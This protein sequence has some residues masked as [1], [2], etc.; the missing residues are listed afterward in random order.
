MGGGGGGWRDTFRTL[1]MDL[2][3]KIFT[4]VGKINPC[5]AFFLLTDSRS[6]SYNALPALAEMQLGAAKGVF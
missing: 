3:S 5:L 2:L 6:V 4:N 1:D